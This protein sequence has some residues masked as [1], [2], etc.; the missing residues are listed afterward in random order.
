MLLKQ[1]FLAGL[2]GMI[3]SILRFLVGITFRSSLFP[4]STLLVN[5]SGSLLIGLFMGWY[6]R[7]AIS[8][9]A[10]ILLV[11][12]ICGGFTTLSALSWEN[13]QLLQEG[14]YGLLIGYSLI[15][16]I[17]GLACVAIGYYFTK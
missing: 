6:T 14:K 10:K 9:D 8:G 7:N 4:L 15:T 3:G 1:I 12:G 11:T 17:G 16:V 2:G 5:L 13:L